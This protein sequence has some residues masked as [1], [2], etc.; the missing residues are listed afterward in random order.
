MSSFSLQSWNLWWGGTKVD[1]GRAK[2][3][4]IISSVGADVICYQECFGDNA[5][6]IS[7]EAGYSHVQ[8]GADC[9]IALARGGT[10]TLEDIATDTSPYATA[11]WLHLG[12][13]LDGTIGGATGGGRKALVW[14]VHLA[15]WDYGPY[16]ALKGDDPAVINTQPEEVQRQE[17]IAHILAVTA[18]LTT[19]STPVVI[20]GDFNSPA[21]LDWQARPDRPDYQWLP[22]DAPLEAGFAD[23]FRAIYPDPCTVWGDT[24]SPIEPLDKEPRD[25]IDFVFVKNLEVL[26]ATVRGARVASEAGYEAPEWAAKSAAESAAE[27]PAFQALDDDASLIPHHQDNLYPSD[28]QIVEVTLRAL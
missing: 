7:R 17:Q 2:I 18:E 15:P 10:F 11:A 5:Q 28:H 9:A 3:Q 6:E 22:T 4:S 26:G 19:D 25:R 12:D 14:S 23:A 8:Q 13:D 1:N 20:S 27:N 21:S 24:W 16:A